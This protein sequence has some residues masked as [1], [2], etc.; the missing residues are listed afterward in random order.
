M[1]YEKQPIHYWKPYA[2]MTDSSTGLGSD[3]L[4]RCTLK[5]QDRQ[6]LHCMSPT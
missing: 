4:V 6:S 1:K 3:V 5:P 2:T